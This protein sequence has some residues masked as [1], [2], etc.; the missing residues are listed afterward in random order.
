MCVTET[1]VAYKVYIIWIGKK[2]VEVDI[3]DKKEKQLFGIKYN[4]I[5]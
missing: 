5:K 3:E 2:T 4:T 1:V